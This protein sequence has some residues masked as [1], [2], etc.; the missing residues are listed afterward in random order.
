MREA[1]LL[2]GSIDRVDMPPMSAYV[3]FQSGFQIL[4]PH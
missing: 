3:A 2:Q 4:Q 1:Q